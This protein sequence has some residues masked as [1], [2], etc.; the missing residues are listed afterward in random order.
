[1]LN[2]LTIFQYYYLN[3]PCIYFVVPLDSEIFLA[4]DVTGFV[5]E[6]FERNVLA[7]QTDMWK[8]NT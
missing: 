4:Q 2:W 3:F 6:L 8:Q 7:K 1:M 5:V